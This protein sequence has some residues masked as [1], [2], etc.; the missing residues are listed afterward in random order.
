MN[1]IGTGVM[2]AVTL[3][4][5]RADVGA[6]IHDADVGTTC[7]FYTSTSRSYDPAS[8]L[9]TDTEAA[10]SCVAWVG[11]LTVKEAGDVQGARV[12]DRHILALASDFTTAPAVESRVSIGGVLH[13][14]YHVES[15]PLATHYHL[16][17][18]KV[19]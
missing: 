2:D 4:G 19:S 1:S 5:I 13:S 11:D 15:G 18:R 17:A 10:T 16:Y 7:L 12:G 6:L 8:G 14:I 3:A 9:V